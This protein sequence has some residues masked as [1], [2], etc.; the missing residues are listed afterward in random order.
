MEEI[1]TSISEKSLEG[2]RS[3]RFSM[4]LI[5]IYVSGIILSII[6]G[7]LGNSVF[8]EG[9]ISNISSTLICYHAWCCLW[10]GIMLVFWTKTLLL[11]AMGIM[12]EPE[13]NNNDR[14]GMQLTQICGIWVLAYALLSFTIVFFVP[15][16]VWVLLCLHVFSIFAQGGEVII[17]RISDGKF[18]LGPII[19]TH[20]VLVQIVGLFFLLY[21][22]YSL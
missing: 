4:L 5:G 3:K 20:H 7:I 1:K 2:K 21:T 8:A 22:Y 10:F 12:E 18:G 11:N 6:L 14:V 15:N 17:K 13:K 9:T 19:N 16:A